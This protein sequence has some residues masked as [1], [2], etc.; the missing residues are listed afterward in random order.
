MDAGSPAAVG[1]LDERQKLSR[2]VSDLFRAGMIADDQK[3]VLKEHLTNQ[4]VSV[5][6]IVATMENMVEGGEVAAP[7]EAELEPVS[8]GSEVWVVRHGERFDEVPGNDWYNTCGDM[9]FDP[10]LTE[11]GRRQAEGS[12]SKLE[13]LVGCG[14]FDRIYCSPLQRCVS[15]AAP[16]SAKFRAPVVLCAGLGECCAALRGQS[17][18]LGNNGSFVVGF[19]RNMLRHGESV[20]L[21][22]ISEL[23]Q[24]CSEAEFGSADGVIDE[25]LPCVER[26]AGAHSRVLIVT[27]REGIRDLIKA[28]GYDGRIKTPYCCIAQFRFDDQ[29]TSR[30]TLGQVLDKQKMK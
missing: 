14:Y 10:P 13:Q 25:Y 12:A 19:T 30:W 16:F 4:A 9:W 29:S 26:L 7:P 1:E 11:K 23:E 2:T 24:L 8:S 27:H 3:R 22:S 28:A 6:T 18:E 17:L 20:P 21:K 5:A 15:T